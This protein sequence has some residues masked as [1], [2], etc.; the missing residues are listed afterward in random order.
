VSRAE[1]DAPLGRRLVLQMQSSLDGFV[2]AVHPDVSWQEWDWGDSTRWDADLRRDF[3]AVF[4]PV[5]TILL[6]RPMLEGGYLDHW[7]RAALTHRSDPDYRF[8]QRILDVDKVAVSA[9]PISTG[10]ERTRVLAAPLTDAVAE[11]KGEGGGD[12]ICFGGVRFASALLEANLVDELQLFVNP[13]A[14]GAGATIF[15]AAAGR[16]WRLSLEGST[17]YECG[18]VVNR[19]RRAGTDRYSRR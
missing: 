12:I 14:L 17:P 11:L 18:I 19:Y 2:D 6:S 10:W 4:D 13:T 3:N 9:Y 7:Q 15:A 5:T 1:T 8:A 16:G